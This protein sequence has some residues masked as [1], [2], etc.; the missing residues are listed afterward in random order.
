MVIKDLGFGWL[1]MPR[2]VVV[3]LG[4]HIWMGKTHILKKTT[5]YFNVLSNIL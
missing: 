4:S 3:D 1:V 5:L 2:V